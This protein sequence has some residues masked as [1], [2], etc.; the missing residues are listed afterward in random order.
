MFFIL[1]KTMFLPSHPFMAAEDLSSLGGE[2]FHISWWEPW[3]PLFLY[4]CWS[5]ERYMLGRKKVSDSMIGY[6]LSRKGPQ[7]CTFLGMQFSSQ[8]DW[9]MT[10]G[11]LE[12]TCDTQVPRMPVIVP[13]TLSICKMLPWDHSYWSPFPTHTIHCTEWPTMCLCVCMCVIRNT[14]K[15]TQNT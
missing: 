14:W 12:V 15:S 3:L 11:I 4:E 7:T 13:I 8:S 2:A 6:N 9:Q 1:S 10:K 5:M